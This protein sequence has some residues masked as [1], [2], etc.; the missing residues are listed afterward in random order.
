MSNRV[1]P[2]EKV[3]IDSYIETTCN[4]YG[5]VYEEFMGWWPQS[6]DLGESELTHTLVRCNE[7]LTGLGLEEK[8]I[9]LSS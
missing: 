9:F 8:I 2:R 5:N 7:K 3:Y 4:M 1:I 6:T